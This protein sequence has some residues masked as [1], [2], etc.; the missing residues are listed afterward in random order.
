MSIEFSLEHPAGG[1]QFVIPKGE[2]TMAQV[3]NVLLVFC[4][5]VIVSFKHWEVCHRKLICAIILS[6]RKLLG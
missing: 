6:L 2:G 5:D 4:S 1:I 3:W